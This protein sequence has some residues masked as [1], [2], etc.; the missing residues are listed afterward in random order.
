MFSVFHLVAIV[1][2]EISQ[3]HWIWKIRMLLVPWIFKN[4]ISPPFSENISEISRYSQ[5]KKYLNNDTVLIILSQPSII[6]DL[7]KN[8]K[9]ET[10]FIW[11]CNHLACER[12]LAFKLQK[13]LKKYYSGDNKRVNWKSS[14]VSFLMET[15]AIFQTYFDTY[16]DLIFSLMLHHVSNNLLVR[17]IKHPPHGE[18]FVLGF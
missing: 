2:K 7:R 9:D 16:Q 4:A 6:M 3:P 15:W 13:I 1:Q 10:L 17:G 14:V 11:T 18:S 8:I 12:G 5:V